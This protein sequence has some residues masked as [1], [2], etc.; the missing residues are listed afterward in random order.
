MLAEVQLLLLL[1]LLLLPATPP[2]VLLLLLSSW[3]A[4]SAACRGC[5]LQAFVRD[6]VGSGWLRM[7]LGMPGAEPYHELRTQFATPGPERKSE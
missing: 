7:H 1:L 6:I 4:L 2:I 5:V 3:C